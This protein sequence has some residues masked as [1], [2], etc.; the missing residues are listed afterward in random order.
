MYKFSEQTDRKLTLTVNFDTNRGM[1]S[2][3]REVIRQVSGGA[4][5]K[6]GCVNTA[7]YTMLVEN[8]NP[9]LF[10]QEFSGAQ[11]PEFIEVTP[12][13]EVINGKKCWVYVSLLDQIV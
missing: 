3:M 2:A 12:R 9:N 1:I 13:I 8:L 11:E 6:Q 7:E 4:I 5:C 10:V